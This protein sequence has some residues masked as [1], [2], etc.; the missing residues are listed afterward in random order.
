M[1]MVAGNVG[2]GDHI[3]FGMYFLFNAFEELR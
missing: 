3:I 2:G 1:E